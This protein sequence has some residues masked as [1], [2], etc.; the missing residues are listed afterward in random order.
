M[1]ICNNTLY[2]NLIAEEKISVDDDVVLSSIFVKILY[3]SLFILTF[4][5]LSI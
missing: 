3:D 4:Y 5:I 1:M 2:V